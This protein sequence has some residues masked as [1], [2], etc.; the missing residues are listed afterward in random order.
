[1]VVVVLWFVESILRAKWHFCCPSIGVNA[2]V[3]SIDYACV[4][5]GNSQY[6]YYGIRIKSMSPLNQVG[7][8]GLLMSRQHVFSQAKRY[9]VSLALSGEPLIDG[10]QCQ[11][12]P[13]DA[14]H[15]R[16]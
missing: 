1:M 2:F 4:C 14:M 9:G 15:P 7:C 11:F 12:L 3:S 5:S 8:D 10:C 6:H 13:R 16:Y